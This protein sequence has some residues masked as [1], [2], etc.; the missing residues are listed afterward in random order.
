MFSLSGTCLLVGERHRRYYLLKPLSIDMVR[1]Q[2]LRALYYKKNQVT[3]AKK[4]LMEFR[5]P[6]DLNTYLTN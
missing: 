6:S 3:F 4:L 2:G 5:S 1:E